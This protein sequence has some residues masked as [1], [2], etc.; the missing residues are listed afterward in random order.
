MLQRF[1]AT[2]SSI[3]PAPE[4]GISDVLGLT[5]NLVIARDTVIENFVAGSSNDAVTG[6]DVANRLEGRAGN[7]RLTGSAGADV[8]DGGAGRDLLWHEGSDAGVRVSFSTGLGSGGHAAGDT[9]ENVEGVISSGHADTLWG[10]DGNDW[11]TGKGGDDVLGGGVGNDNLV[12]GAGADAMDGGAGYDRL[13]CSGSEAAVAVD[14]SAGTAS[15][16]DAEGDTVEYVEEIVGS[17]HADTL[18]GGDGNDWLVGQGGDDVL[19][20]LVAGAGA[21]RMDGGVG[22]D[23]LWHAGSDAGVNVSLATGTGS[24]GHAE[25]DTGDCVGGHGAAAVVLG[26]T[27]RVSL[28]YAE[29]FAPAA[30]FGRWRSRPCAPVCTLR[31]LP[32]RSCRRS[33]LCAAR[34][35]ARRPCSAVHSPGRSPV[36]PSTPETGA[37][38]GDRAVLCTAPVAHLFGRRRRRP[39]PCSATGQCCAQPRSLTC[40][41]VDAGDR[42]LARRPGS[43]VHSPGRSP[44][45]PSTPET[46]AL[47]GDRAVLCTAPVAHLFGRRR[48]RPAPCSATGQC[49]AQPRSLTC[50]AVDAGD[51]RLARR[52]GSAVHGPGRSPV[53]PSTPETGALLGDRAVL[54]TAPVAHLFGRRHRRPA[55]CSATGQCCAQSRSLTCSA[56]DA[57]DRRLARRP[58]S[59]VHSPGRS[60]VRPSTP[61]TGALLGDRAVLCTVP[62]A[63]LS[64]VLSSP[65]RPASYLALAPRPL[66][67]SVRRL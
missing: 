38:L 44:V 47:L 56:V 67:S 40:S 61:E 8:M 4:E 55:P 29:A 25:G 5:G 65:V 11:L 22:H 19:D 26:C 10:G 66:A 14:L 18:W 20:G 49:C 12:G 60:P 7:D 62:S 46:G 43:A 37:L 36:R 17:G 42:R 27:A 63:P 51:R 3:R 35:L 57:G 53:R 31:P 41:A 1:S 24:G 64:L 39:A 33:R 6:N 15:G 52:P 58:G 54:C 32:D 30:G 45:R 23:W 9:F 48:R 34:C 16:G 2:C 50:S 21:D 13:W 28:L 59:A